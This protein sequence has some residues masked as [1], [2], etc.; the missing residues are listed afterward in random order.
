[1]ASGGFEPVT[2]FAR[3]LDGSRIITGNL[4]LEV[5]ALDLI[6]LVSTAIEAVRPAAEA[7]RIQ[8]AVSLDPAAAKVAGDPDRLQQVIWNL[9]SNAIKFTPKD[10]T[11]SVALRR[12]GTDVELIVEDSG[13]GINP[14]F[15]P[16]VFD[17]FRQAQ[18]G[19]ARRHG[20]LGL[21]LAL[22]RHLVEAHGGSVRA[23]S[24]GVGL[25]SRFT[26]TL[27]VQA[28]FPE[29]PRL[30]QQSATVPEGASTHDTLTGMTV[31]VVDDDEDARDLVS[32]VLLATGAQV[33]TAPNAQRA[34]DLLGTRS[35]SAVVSDI[36]MPEMDGYEL[37]RQSRARSGSAAPRGA[38]HRADC[39]RTRRRPPPRDRSGLRRSRRQTS[40]SR[41][42]RTPGGTPCRAN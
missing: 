18:A 42:A 7:K 39:L 32:T 3:L 9:V 23:E 33:M 30:S 13:E 29:R 25:G 6:V 24:G 2:T 14:D 11:V 10:G 35:F 38:R 28:V 40:R 27:P 16:Y 8:L 37:I 31:L 17:R 41:R 34:L 21:G 26:V 4:H 5:R 1:M 15:L 19:T 22:V 12:T 20:G 36:G